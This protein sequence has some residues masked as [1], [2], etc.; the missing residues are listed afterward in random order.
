VE[1]LSNKIISNFHADSLFPKIG[2][3]LE[4]YLTKEN[5]QINDSKLIESF[6]S[7]LS[8]QA[9]L[10]K[11]NLLGIEKEQGAG[12][13]EIKISPSQDMDKIAFDIELLKVISK[14]LAKQNG[15]EALFN[16]TP[17]L[18]DCSSAL[19][20]NLSILDENNQNLFNKNNDQESNILL[21]SIGGLL[22][23]SNQDI[24]I[25]TNGIIDSSRF[26]LER[27]RELFKKGKYT[28][29][30]N[31]SWGY[32]NRSCAIRVIGTQDK[33]RLEFRIPHSS[34]NTGQS[35]LKLLELVKDG[36]DNEAEP[37]KAVYGN[38]FDDKYSYLEKISI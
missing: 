31:L 3:E 21:N 1:N 27:N 24:K 16:P 19:Q 17:F 10:Q 36:I 14:E 38:A 6:I 25:F 26:E 15:L 2:I 30:V 20:I 22:K 35:I 37:I 9:D 23:L 28:S 7:Q 12:Q 34:A 13:I 5:Q 32:N 18:D 8:K 4:F 29:P 33:R 11:I